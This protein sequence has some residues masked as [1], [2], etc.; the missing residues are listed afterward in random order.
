MTSDTFKIID[1]MKKTVLERCRER[2]DEA[3]IKYKDNIKP[4][5]EIHGVTSSMKRKYGL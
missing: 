2:I 5:K 1:D 3:A 4:S